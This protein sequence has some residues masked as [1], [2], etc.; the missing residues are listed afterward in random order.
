[1]LAAAVENGRVWQLSNVWTT[2][3]CLRYFRRRMLLS[4]A[5]PDAWW[6]T[7]VRECELF[8]P[9]ARPAP[10]LRWS[11]RALSDHSTDAA[12]SYQPYQPTHFWR[13]TPFCWQQQWKTDVY[14]KRPTSQPRSIISSWLSFAFIFFTNNHSAAAAVVCRGFVPLICGTTKWC[15]SENVRWNGKAV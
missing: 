11:T 4:P 6:V 5:F 8:Y 13:E 14:P 3:H 9:H 10:R 12:C 7:L 15:S 1:M 2:F